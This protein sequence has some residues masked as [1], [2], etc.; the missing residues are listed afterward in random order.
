MPKAVLEHVARE[1]GMP[2]FIG[3]PKKDFIINAIVEFNPNQ[4]SDEPNWDDLS[5]LAQFLDH[6]F[7]QPLNRKADQ[8]AATIGLSNEEPFINKFWSY[9][10]SKKEAG[11]QNEFSKLNLFSIY[12]L[13]LVQ[14]KKHPFV[15]GSANGLLFVLVSLF[16]AFYYIFSFSS[17]FF[18][19]YWYRTM[20][21]ME[22]LYH[23]ASNYNSC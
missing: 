8:D 1:K 14:N 5:P 22:T 9:C 10:L 2:C 13:G 20:T 6:S 7:L 4:Q 15:K 18:F 23:Q 12:H 3:N 19:R 16:F 11:K 21:M 17:Y